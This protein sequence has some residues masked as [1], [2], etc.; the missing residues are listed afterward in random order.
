MKR[1]SQMEIMGLAIVII[2]L[3]LGLVFVVR[4][5]MLKQPSD[6]RGSFVPSQLASNTLYSFLNS[7]VEECSGIQISELLRVCAQGRSV[8]CG[9]RQIGCS[10]IKDTATFIFNQTLDKWNYRYYFEVHF[11][12]G[13]TLIEV[14]TPCPAE[15]TFKNFPTPTSSGTLYTVLEICK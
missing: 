2:L 5:V 15:K 7:N 1:K 13:N 3:I 11:K 4:F 8:S 6:V 10:Y 12:D 14:G 9:N